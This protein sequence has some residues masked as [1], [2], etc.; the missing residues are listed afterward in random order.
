MSASFISTGQPTY[1]RMI[2]DA[3]SAT[4]P[5]VAPTSTKPSSRII[6][7]VNT[8]YPTLLRVMP[9]STVNNATGT[10]MRV[11]G[12]TPGAI[13]KYYT[14]LLTYSEQFDNAAWLKSNI[15]VSGAS[16]N[17]ETAPDGTITA[18]RVLETGATVNHYI[19]RDTGSPGASTDIRKFSVYAKGG[20]GRDFFSISAGNSSGGPYYAVTVNLNTGAVTQAD[21]VNTGTWFTTTPTNT[22]TYVGNGWYRI[23]I[24]A[25]QVQYYLTS[26]NTTGTPASGSNW[27]L[28]SYASDVTKGVILWGGQLEW[29]TTASPY[30]QTVASTVQ[31]IDS[32]TAATQVWFSTVLA[33]F[34]LTYS[35][36]TVP[37]ATVNNVPNYL[38]STATQVAIGPD[39][40]LYRPSQVTASS[41][42]LASFVVDA[43]GHQLIELQ[44][45]GS[46]G[47]MGAMWCSI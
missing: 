45:K 37:S 41:V 40:S 27:G 13:P 44:F 36:G 18:D 39:A 22:V 43:I 8:D 28:G 47:T 5:T 38:F 9:F 35:T 16:I 17:A 10:G 4:Y 14:N 6:Y 11:I 2:G 29:G 15:A 32:T 34:T 42:E 30:V 19:G 3:V 20:L 12:W 25:R 24:T 1:T 46:T 31:T 33:D 26:P 21:L 7:D 23:S